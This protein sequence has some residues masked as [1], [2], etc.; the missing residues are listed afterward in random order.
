MRFVFIEVA[1]L[2]L[3]PL[4]LRSVCN[5]HIYLDGA[6]LLIDQT[7]LCCISEFKGA[8]YLAFFQNGRC[9]NEMLQAATA[10]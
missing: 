1:G 6:C 5:I 2:S 9:E 10:D 7:H 3:G 4:H 8:A